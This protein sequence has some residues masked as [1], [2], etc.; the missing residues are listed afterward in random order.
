M[1]ISSFCH[2]V[3]REGNIIGQKDLAQ[4]QLLQWP[5]VFADVSNVNLFYGQPVLSEQEL[6][7]QSAE[8]ISRPG[9]GKMRELFSDIHMKYAHEEGTIYFRIENQSDICNVMPV[10]DM[11][12]QQQ[13][14]KIVDTNNQKNIYPD[15]FTHILPDGQKLAPVITLILNYSKKEWTAPV[16]LKEMIKFP[17]HL[18]GKIEPLLS[19][20]SIRVVNLAHQTEETVKKYQSDFRMVV[21]YL[22]NPKERLFEKWIKEGR[23]IRHP[24]ELIDLLCV[25]SKDKRYVDIREELLEKYVKG[26]EI[27]MCELLDILE[28]RGVE[29]GIRQGREEMSSKL[30]ALILKL[31]EEK[32][33]EKLARSAVDKEYQKKLMQQYH[34][35]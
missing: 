32:H 3:K 16:D 2:T 5:D 6:T 9:G 19:N 24:M 7:I 35:L 8:G 14:K 15:K 25:L 21:E 31:T 28:N 33:Y 29:K 20:H 1:L 26:D 23:K 27:E 18:K 11:G 13:V 10:R 34:I 30:N 4:K 12:Y 22:T 17:R